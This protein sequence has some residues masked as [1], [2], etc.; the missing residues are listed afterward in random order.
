MRCAPKAEQI[1]QLLLF[2]EACEIK[3]DVPV[4]ISNMARVIPSASEGPQPGWW[5]TDGS[6][7]NHLALARCFTPKP[8]GVRHDARGVIIECGS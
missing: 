4:P 6:L 2:P 8:F 5:I 1:Q 7:R 3:W